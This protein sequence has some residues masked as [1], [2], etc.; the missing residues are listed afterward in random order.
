VASPLEDPTAEG[1]RIAEAAMGAGLALRVG[2]GVG[3]ALRCPSIGAAPLARRHADIDLFGRRRDSGSIADLLA[4][5]GYEPDP[6]FNVLHGSKRL[7]FWDTQNA[8]QVDV[9]LDVFEMCHRL[10]LSKRIDLPGETLPLAD[11]LLCKLQIVETNEKDLVDILALVLD[12][13]FSED[14]RGINLAYIAGLA[15]SDWGLWKTTTLVAQRTDEHA[16][17]IEGLGARKQV[18]EQVRVLLERLE[19]EPKTHGWRLRSR[20]GERMRWYELPEVAH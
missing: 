12:H 17:R 6:Q 2:G 1:R 15:G 4:G 19:R 13:P 5:L 11:L 20:I 3:I 16:R 7:F 8:R 18:H 10:D 9:F 14:E